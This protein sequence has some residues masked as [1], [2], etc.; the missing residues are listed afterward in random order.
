MRVV[1]PFR[2]RENAFS[3]AEIVIALS[4]LLLLMGLAVP[5]LLRYRGH[6]SVNR[7]VEISK[8][9]LER[10]TEEAKSSGYPLST[11][12]TEAGLTEAAQTE[13]TPEAPLKVRIRKRTAPG[14]EAAVVSER[15]FPR[16]TAI[17]LG[18]QNLGTLDLTSQTD[19]LGVFVEWVENQGGGEAILA[20]VPIDINGQ[21]VLQGNQANARV[22]F[23]FGDYQRSLELT[24]RG[25]VAVD[26][27]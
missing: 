24:R 12:L 14:R 6:T 5:F 3:L 27:R 23:A 13:S 16:S 4:I 15:E 11:S 17:R 10:A 7:A 1:K 19:Q 25:V 18:L 8:A 9:V 21:Y 2:T 20:T 22:L 26:R